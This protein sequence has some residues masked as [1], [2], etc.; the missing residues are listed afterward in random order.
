[1]LEDLISAGEVE[2]ARE[3]LAPYYPA[4]S[5]PAPSRPS[6]FGPLDA[7]AISTGTDNANQGTFDLSWDA[8]KPMF[9]FA[10]M[11]LNRLVVHPRLIT[12]AE[13]LLGTDQIRLYQGLASAK[14]SEGPRDYEQLL[15]V[16]YGN[17]TLTVP[18]TD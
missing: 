9:P 14:Y 18:R 12:L 7:A 3:A 11:V 5:N 17:H 10:E 15:H 8:P 16:D 13:V 1:M 2:A 6:H 4:P